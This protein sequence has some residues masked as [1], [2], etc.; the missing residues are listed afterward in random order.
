VPLVIAAPGSKAAGKSVAGPVE[1]IDV[2]PTLAELCGLELPKGEGRSVGGT[3]L[4]GKSLAP[5]LADASAATKGFALSQVRRGG[6]GGGKKKKA[7][8]AAAFPGYSLRTPRWRY[9]EWDSGSKG[10][11]LY[12]HESDPHEFTNLAQD[13]KHAGTVKELA[14]TLRELT[15]K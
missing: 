15:A 13:P 14:A 7:A 1:L 12:D 6:G 4:Q 11:E 8:A 3:Q 10:V 9:T 5:Q 2:Y